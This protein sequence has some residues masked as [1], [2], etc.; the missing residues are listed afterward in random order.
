[1]FVYLSTIFNLLRS[2]S[3]STGSLDRTCLCAHLLH[4]HLELCVHSWPSA[5]CSRP[6]ASTCAPCSL[7]GRLGCWSQVHVWGLGRRSTVG[8]RCASAK[9]RVDPTYR[10]S[11]AHCWDSICPGS[12]PTLGR[13]QV[14]PDTSLQV[15]SLQLI[16][17]KWIKKCKL[18]SK[19]VFRLPSSRL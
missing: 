1:M 3:C 10:G 8:H 13:R 2:N 9:A 5:L 18:K 15:S 14:Q 12:S 17:I 7:P 11:G 4:H 6:W 16:N 19:A